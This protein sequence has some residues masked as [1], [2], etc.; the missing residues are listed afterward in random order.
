MALTLCPNC[1]LPVNASS[2]KCHLCD[3]PLTTP[4]AARHVPVAAAV[5]LV[6]TL[7]MLARRKA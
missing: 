1:R 7:A 2:E 4:S 3:A 6:A 5:A